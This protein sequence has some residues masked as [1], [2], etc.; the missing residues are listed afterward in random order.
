MLESLPHRFLERV[1]N[2]RPVM[3]E[4]ILESDVESALGLL[5]QEVVDGLVA[6]API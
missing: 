2:R 5:V 1:V 6:A 4:G 3:A